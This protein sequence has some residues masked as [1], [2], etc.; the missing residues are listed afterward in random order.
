MKCIWPAPAS[1]AFWI[2]SASQARAESSHDVQIDESK[3]LRCRSTRRQE[4]R[5]RTL[6]DVAAVRVLVE[7][8]LD[9]ADERAALTERQAT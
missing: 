3:K 7:H 8:A 1:S 5:A 4:E 2:N 6:E 9:A